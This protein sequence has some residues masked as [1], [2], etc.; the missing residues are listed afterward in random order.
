MD[1]PKAHQKFLPQVRAWK[2]NEAVFPSRFSADDL[3]Y[4]GRLKGL[5]KVVIELVY[6][7]EDG[8]FTAQVFGTIP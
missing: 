4:V 5:P 7:K 2:L 1:D 8:K 6:R 3:Y